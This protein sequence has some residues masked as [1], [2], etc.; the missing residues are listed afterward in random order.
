MFHETLGFVGGIAYHS[1]LC[2]CAKWFFVYLELPIQ[3][4][5]GIS[6]PRLPA[7]SASW[8]SAEG[9]FWG[10]NHNQ[11]PHRART[12]SRWAAVEQPLSWAT[13]DEAGKK[14]VWWYVG[15]V[16]G[17]WKRSGT[18]SF[19]RKEQQCPHRRIR[20]PWKARVVVP[21]ASVGPTR[22]GPKELALHE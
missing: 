14:M 20:N 11:W 15:F 17:I 19:E 9:T 12:R 5:L 10:S 16:E 2:P 1:F 22:K 21:W 3:D 13:Q 18:R 6:R 7:F 8:P 4:Q